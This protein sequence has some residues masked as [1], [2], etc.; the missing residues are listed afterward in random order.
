MCGLTGILAAEGA[1]R[2]SMEARLASMTRQLRHRGPDDEGVWLD[3]NAGIGLGFRRLSIFDLSPAGH[4]PMTSSSGRYTL[5]FNG[6][7]YNF[8]ELRDAL[9][10]HGH[11]FRGQSDTEVILAAFEQW[12]VAGAVP[13]FIGM[14]AIAVWDA[15]TRTLVLLRDR[16]GIKPLYYHRRPGVLSFGSEL[17]ALRADPGFVG[18]IDRIALEEYLRHLYI[19][20]PRTIFR[21]TFKLPPGH[22][23]SVRDVHS[24][25]PEP[26]PYWSLPGVQRDG[27]ERRFDGTDAEVISEFRA[28]LE[29]AVRLRMQADVPLGALLS[30]G[31]DSS[32][33]V[34][35][36]QSLDTRR[37]KTFTI[38]FDDR[39]YDESAHAA[40][41]ARHLGTDHTQLTVTASDALAVVPDL[42]HMFDEPLADPSHIPTFLV[43][44]LARK[45]VTVA[46]T[47]DGGDELFAGYNRYLHGERLLRRLGAIPAP[48]RRLGGTAIRALSSNGWE[49]LH[50]AASPLLASSLRP[51]L[52][53]EKIRR[54]GE[55]LD[56]PTPAE[57]YRALVSAHQD[58]GNLLREPAPREQAFVG[59]WNA[60][61]SDSLL[62]RMML[63]DQLAYLPDDLLAK[64]DRASMAV[65]LEA[66]VP[67]LDHRV[68]EF[69]WRLPKRFKIREGQGKW[70]LRQ[71]LYS[72]VPRSIVERPKMGFT[73][74]VGAWLRGDLRD[75][76][77]ALLEEDGL[78][79]DGLFDP[80]TLRATWMR[81]QHGHADLALSLWSVLQFQAWL[82]A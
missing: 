2:D 71:V 46:L 9:I 33:V 35:L 13:R 58:P 6:A 19:A 79:H 64:V 65:S 21:D 70:L 12:G 75:W 60:G 25:L 80:A 56:Q 76:A 16:L 31:I 67:I 22:L 29:S 57:R 82:H 53:G 43:S 15:Q 63:A 11:R 38:G 54:I 8:P 39:V 36:M 7:V 26:E 41:V 78:R 4:Q 40:A 66:R 24:L 50:R 59:R 10:P 18:E 45:S 72:V 20:A 28:L 30:G 47:G 77:E 27:L 74:P 81:F 32:T 49:R 1:E 34:G 69:S 62:D 51:R 23:L 42:P 3:E 44:R 55:V 73:P 52:A 17:K 61:A 14:F 48:V 68:V 5:V 37:V